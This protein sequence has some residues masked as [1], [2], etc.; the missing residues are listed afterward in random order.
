[1]YIYL[2]RSSHIPVYRQIQESMRALIEQ[3]ALRP[4]DRIPST[5]Q[6]GLE[7]GINRM[8]VAA[9]FSQL[10]AEGLVTVQLGRGTFVNRSAKAKESKRRLKETDAESE[11]RLWAPLFVDYRS[12][13]K[14]IPTLHSQNGSDVIS[15]VAAAPGPD[16]F[17]SVEFR[18]CADFV[19]K[20]RIAD[21]S[22]VGS[23]N[24][25]ASLKTCL[26]QR[27]TQNGMP[28][29]EDEILITTGC[30]QS[31][32]LIR[33]VLIAPG[34]AL[35]LENPTYP[36][37]IA[38]LALPS[39]KLLELAINDEGPDLR[40]LTSMLE[41]NRCKLI[42]VVPN[43]QNPT[44]RTLSLDA[45]TRLAAVARQYRI[46][47]VEDDVFG[48]LRYSGP[49][50]PTL[51]SLCPELV[52]YIGSFSKMLTPSLRLGWIL[53]PRPV[54]SQLSIVK[55][56]SDLYTSLL[57]QTI[58]DEFCR[59]GLLNRHMKRVR[60]VFMKRRDAMAEALHTYF[61][62]DVHFQVPEGGLSVWV[63]FSHDIRT[64]E[65]AR[66]ASERGVQFLPGSNFYFRSHFHNF[67]RLSFAME[68]EKRIG[69]GIRI[70]GSLLS[71]R[72]SH[73]SL[74]ARSDQRDSQPIL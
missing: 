28:V 2:D 54:I 41:G 8:T 24:G 15:F 35:A 7:L 39:S 53:A 25:L 32:D 29:S 69:E 61:P 6:L 67:I 42:Y 63:A 37:A 14:P 50:L 3:G 65:L 33:K 60:N 68:P 1:M 48:E 23:S 62:S 36:G 27:F 16:S 71:N 45:R 12:A 13:P 4:G 73:F 66:L 52:I 9:A 74:T 26:T 10:E 18:R 30:Q 64:E 51:R 17:P 5:R 43:F 31:M 20:R 70:I 56:S 34:D 49:V 19:L 11:S 40:S 72:R 57:T 22:R 58:M 47:L 44:G 21:I 59:R 38:A 55:E 46:S